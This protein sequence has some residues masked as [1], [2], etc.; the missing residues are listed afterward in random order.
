ML[1]RNILFTNDMLGSKNEKPGKMF[2]AYILLLKVFG[3]FSF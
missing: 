1:E 3:A 2:E